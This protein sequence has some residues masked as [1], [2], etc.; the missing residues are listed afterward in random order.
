MF[1]KNLKFF[2]F[3]KSFLHISPIFFKKSKAFV[4]NND[5]F[6]FYWSSLI[7]FFCC[8][9]YDFSLNYDDCLTFLLIYLIFMAYFLSLLYLSLQNLS[10][11][12]QILSP[13]T[14]MGL[15]YFNHYFFY[16][17]ISLLL[18][19]QN[20]FFY[21]NLNGFQIE[22]CFSFFTFCFPIPL[23]QKPLQKIIFI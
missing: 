3:T 19:L 15:P 10:L 17:L 9:V 6:S 16:L 13:L 12:Y 22:I 11:L 20:Y 5:I 23:T 1:S 14:F 8:D 18:I 4:F 7:Y 2:S 21:L